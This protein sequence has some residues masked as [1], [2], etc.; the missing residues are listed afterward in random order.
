MTQDSLKEKDH[1]PGL[2]SMKTQTLIG[3]I[4]I[5]NIKVPGSTAFGLRFNGFLGGF[6]LQ[7]GVCNLKKKNTYI[8]ILK[9]SLLAPVGSMCCSSI[10]GPLPEAWE[11]EGAAQYLSFS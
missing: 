1:I 4:T 5:S 9:K 6:L 11:F 7:G 10:L 3:L 8:Y 2:I